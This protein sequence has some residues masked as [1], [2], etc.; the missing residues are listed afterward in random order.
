MAKA[1]AFQLYAGDFLTGTTLMSNAEVGLFIRLLCLQAEH[2]SIPDDVERIVRAYG[3]EAR[4]LWTAV[5]PKFNHGSTSG[6]LVNDRMVEVLAARDAFRK[7]QSNAGKASAQSR[8]NH[9]STAV[10]QPLPSGST[11]VEPLEEGDR[12][13]TQEKKEHASATTRLPVPKVHIPEIIPEGVTPA[14]WE[15]IKRWVKYREESRKK[16]TPSGLEAFIKKWSSVGE[17][18]AIAA[19]DNSIAQGWQGCYEQQQD[20]RRGNTTMTNEEQF[21]D[22]ANHFAG[23]IRQQIERDQ[24]GGGEHV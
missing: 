23:T 7:R 16:L 18:R 9:G 14:T 8:S 22:L 24:A 1:P 5:R 13:T 2:G 17:E 21:T 19:I 15:A 3:E 11:A 4:S 20:Q 6:T 12:D 10:Q